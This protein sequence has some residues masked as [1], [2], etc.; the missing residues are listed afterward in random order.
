M[1]II[2]TVVQQVVAISDSTQVGQARRAASNLAESIGWNERQIGKLSLIVTELSTNI[3]KHAS[4]G[5]LLL[6]PSESANGNTQIDVIAI[7]RGPGI[8][9]LSKSLEDGYSTAG[10]SGTGLGAI[11]RQ[12]DFFEVFSSS[13]SGTVLLARVASNQNGSANGGNGHHVISPDRLQASFICFPIKGERVSG[14]SVAIRVSGCQGM[15]MVADGLGHGQD[16]AIASLEACKIFAETPEAS[17]RDALENIHSGLRT[18]RGAAVAVAMIDCDQRV[19][20][21][22]G[23]GNIAG[24]IVLPEGTRSLVSHNGIIGH[25]SVRA[26]EFRYEWPE[27]GILVMNSDGLLT[28]WRLTNYPGILQKDPAILAAVLYRDFS[29]GR[30][31]LSVLVVRENPSRA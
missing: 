14:D 19:L 13:G 5:E 18:T 17:P 8:S 3:V 1:E 15:F 30:D 29:R 10:S 11:R 7:D 24:A 27:G 6:C 16:A 25:Q 4:S 28:N 20:K 26:Q 9:D 21:Y 31:D 2:S 22:S 12:A 23:V